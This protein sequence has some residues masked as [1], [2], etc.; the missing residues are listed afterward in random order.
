MTN[1]GGY[2]GNELT[3]ECM[4]NGGGG[5][6]GKEP[7]AAYMTNGGGFRNNSIRIGIYAD[8][9]GAVMFARENSLPYVVGRAMN[10]ANVLAASV[11]KDAFAVLPAAEITA[12]DKRLLQE[13]ARKRGVTNIADDGFKIAIDFSTEA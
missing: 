4:T 7:T 5:S 11:F 3:A 1:G 8:N 9:A 12:A 6:E 2:E 10:V 13:N